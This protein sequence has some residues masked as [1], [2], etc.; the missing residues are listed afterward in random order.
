V[1]TSELLKGE[2]N[3]TLK[4]LHDFAKWKLIVT[5]ALAAAAFG[6]TS[7]GGQA[8]YWMLL[9]IPYAC[10]YIDLNCYQYLIRIT[11]ISRS[12]RM[13]S[14]TDEGLAR[15]ESLCHELRQRGV[16]SLGEYAEVAVSL[17]ISLVAPLFAVFQ[18]QQDKRPLE[19][20]L[21]A[22]FWLLGVLSVIGLWLYYKGKN[23]VAETDKVVSGTLEL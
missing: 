11:V 15:Y 22:A 20:C 23:R 16:F 5:S 21:A 4:S 6:L 12:L 17:A 9:L 3:Q 1:K 8:R 18:F 10:G 13:A 14:K 7:T 2:I 19:M